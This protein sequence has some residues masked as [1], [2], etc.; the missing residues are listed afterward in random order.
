M[1]FSPNLSLDM[2]KS[3]LMLLFLLH[4]MF[5]ALPMHARMQRAISTE[6]CGA[7]RQHIAL[8]SP[9][10]EVLQARESQQAGEQITALCGLRNHHGACVDA[11]QTPA[12]PHPSKPFL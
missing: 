2:I 4:F 5:M 9:Q 12:L 6:G 7:G 1:D 11:K 8:Y 10:G 3:N